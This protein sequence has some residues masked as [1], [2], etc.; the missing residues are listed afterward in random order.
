MSRSALLL[1][2]LLICGLTACSS[3]PEIPDQQKTRT[4]QS[5]GEQPAAQ[6]KAEPAPAQTESQPSAPAN[7]KLM[8]ATGP[9]AIVNG[10]PLSAEKF[11]T[12]VNQLASSGQ[13]PPT[14]INSLK[15][16][17]VEGM[18]DKMLLDQAVASSTLEV[19]DADI[20]AKLKQA[21]ADF[22]L[23]KKLRGESMG[24]FEGMFKKMNIKPEDVRPSM[25]E[26]LIIEHLVKG[27]GYTPA[28]EAKIKST[29]EQNVAKF[30]MPPTVRARHIL[31]MVPQGGPSPEDWSKAEAKI[32]AIRKDIVD[33]KK[34][35]AQVAKEKSEG[36][37]KTKGGDLGF[38]AK[39]Q[40]VGP[41]ADAAFA[42]KDGELS[43][44]VKTNFGWHL[45]KREASKPGFVMPYEEA[46]G[47]IK[48]Q[49][50]QQA[51]QVIMKDYLTKLRAEAKVEYKLENIK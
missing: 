45:I 19:T 22:E 13:V 29:Y 17:L 8:Q 3:A 23:M 30:T 34:D 36:P 43:Q 47:V 4:Y 24:T 9:V 5:S 42:L 50:D 39:Q 16:R 11:N 46:K 38:F 2:T 20:D 40:M 32:K 51:Y 33:N 49:L 10:E 44:P 41:F 48:S 12:R 15:Q 26:A 35:F 14:Y 37:S 18:V 25:K 21:R 27:Q 6:V 1:G 7:T 31:I 28:D